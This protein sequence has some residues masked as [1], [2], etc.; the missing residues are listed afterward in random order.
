MPAVRTDTPSRFMLQPGE[1]LAITAAAA[2]NGRVG[3]LADASGSVVP[4]VPSAF[5]AIAAGLSWVIGPFQT[6]T[7]HLV[8]SF[9]GT[10]SCAITNAVPPLPISGAP[11]DI[12]EMFGAGVPVAYTDGDPVAT[13]QGTAGKGSRYTDISAGTLYI[14]TGTKAQPAWTQLAPVA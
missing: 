8:E 9:A 6:R 3:R 11:T 14:N 10:L 5:Q 4:D 13:G 12:V 7:H 2:S 1:V